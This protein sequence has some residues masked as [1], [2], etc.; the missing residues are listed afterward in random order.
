M[1]KKAGEKE[2]IPK[3]SDYSVIRHKTTQAQYPILVG[4]ERL[5]QQHTLVVLGIT[6]VKN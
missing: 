2:E 3:M 6:K 1:N 4:L 5:E